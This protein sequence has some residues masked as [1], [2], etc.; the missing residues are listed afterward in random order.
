MEE[1]PPSRE[2][3]DGPFI[4]ESTEA[5]VNTNGP[6]DYIMEKL[7]PNSRDIPE[8]VFMKTIRDMG[9]FGTD[10]TAHCSAV[11][12]LIDEYIARNR[13]LKKRVM[14]T[15]LRMKNFLNNPRRR[16]RKT[17]SIGMQAMEDHHRFT[18]AL[19]VRAE[20]VTPEVP[21]AIL[22]FASAI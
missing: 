12:C 21:V 6:V 8:L 16:W 17:V 19:H 22:Y 5:W 15:L 18:A 3:L 14:Q 20:D 4:S 13:R 9:R 7:V 10:L 1:P 11:V 2:M